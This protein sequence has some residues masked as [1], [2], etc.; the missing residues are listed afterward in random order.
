MADYSEIDREYVRDTEA[1]LTKLQGQLAAAEARAEAAERKN[2]A[3]L[4][5]AEYAAPGERAYMF[6]IYRGARRMAPNNA[7]K[8]EPLG[9]GP[10]F[11]VAA[12]DLATKLGLL[13]PTKTDTKPAREE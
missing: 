13:A 12:I 1:L 10:D 7:V 8:F 5:L 2:E 4:A 6:G 9:I 11:G 3:W